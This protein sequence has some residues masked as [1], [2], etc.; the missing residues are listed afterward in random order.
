MNSRRHATWKSFTDFLAQRAGKKYF[1]YGK[2]TVV[3]GET[4][5][6]IVVAQTMCLLLGGQ[7]QLGY[8]WPPLDAACAAHVA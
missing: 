7:K 4:F 1:A 2:M 5:V 3:L 8:R 6:T